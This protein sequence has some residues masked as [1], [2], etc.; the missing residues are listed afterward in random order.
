MKLIERIAWAIAVAVLI[1]LLVRS[2]NRSCPGSIATHDTTWRPRTD[3][4]PVHVPTITGKVDP[5]KNVTKKPAEVFTGTGFNNDFGTEVI[6]DTIPGISDTAGIINDYFT[7][8]GYIDSVNIKNGKLF[9]YDSVSRNR[10]YWRK[11]VI[12]DSIPVVTTHPFQVYAGI[13]VLGNKAD[14]LS[15]IG[16]NLTFKFGKDYMITAGGYKIKNSDPLF[17]LGVKKLITFKRKR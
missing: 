10:I 14:P 11:T 2:C 5:P 4:S 8:Y 15:G 13:D 3:S 12:K 16:V 1:F 17:M 7:R 9:I 6:H